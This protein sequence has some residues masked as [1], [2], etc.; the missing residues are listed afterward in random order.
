VRQN[1]QRQSAALDLVG[2]DGP[3]LDDARDAAE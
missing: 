1:K 3:A 2:K